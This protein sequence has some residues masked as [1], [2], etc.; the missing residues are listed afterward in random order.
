MWSYGRCIGQFAPARFLISND[1]RIQGT[2][3][4]LVQRTQRHRTT[5]E[6]NRLFK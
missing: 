3:K 6:L 4:E 2:I 1:G 5:P